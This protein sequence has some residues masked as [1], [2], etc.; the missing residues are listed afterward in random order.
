MIEAALVTD[1]MSG[2]LESTPDTLGKLYRFLLLGIDAKAKEFVVPAL[3]W[4]TASARPLSVEVLAAAVRFKPDSVGSNG[5]DEEPSVGEAEMARLFNGLVNIVDNTV[6]LVHASLAEFLRTVSE[7]PNDPVS[8]F[9]VDELGAQLLLATTCIQY[10][11]DYTR[12]P[13]RCGSTPDL[14]T[15]PLL[16]YACHFWRYHT[17][18]WAALSRG[19]S[20]TLP[21][22]PAELMAYLLWDEDVVRAWTSVYHPE[23]P[24]SPP[25]VRRRVGLASPVYTAVMTGIPDVVERLAS[26]GA[27]VS[28]PGASGTY[29]LQ[30]ALED[31]RWEMVHILLE[32]GASTTV[33]DSEGLM[34]LLEAAL[35]GRT[36]IVALLL[37]HTDPSEILKRYPL[38]DGTCISIPHRVAAAATGPIFSYFLRPPLGRVED[39]DA[40]VQNFLAA[41][42]AELSSTPLHHA[43][44]SGNISVVSIIVH[45]GADVNA[46]DRDGNTALHLAAVFNHERAWNLLIDHGALV[47][48]ENASH[49]TALGVNWDR[50]RLDWASYKVDLVLSRGMQANTKVLVKEPSLGTPDSPQVSPSRPLFGKNSGNRYQT[51]LLFTSTSSK[52]A[53][54]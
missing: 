45:E 40:H 20:S 14:E 22:P 17:R 1:S 15:F 39:T 38:E 12:S 41:R 33:V 7:Q 50:R 18:R 27:N 21:G 32:H 46:R 42:D 28:L 53:T 13:K 19:P 10:V 31:E 11:A 9:A 43:V 37:R 36:A 2:L 26:S 47:D 52:S 24:G 54:T 4:L 16:R 51:D 35:S 3:L 48:I 49:Q 34:P 29:P 25:F 6:L 5:S 23:D 30:A 44:K 8:E